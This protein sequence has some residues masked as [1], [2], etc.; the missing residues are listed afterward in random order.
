MSEVAAS[1]VGEPLRR[2]VDGLSDDLLT[3]GLG[4][5]G[6]RAAPPPCAD[7]RRPTTTELRRRAVHAAYRGLVDVTEAGGYGRYYGPGD[8]RGI[9]G[10]EYL[11]ALRTP[12]G[13]GTTTV[14]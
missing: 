14:M 7:P 13:A 10:I 11:A 1:I 12:D 6:L 3:A 2:V 4:G 5:A 9:A 8:D